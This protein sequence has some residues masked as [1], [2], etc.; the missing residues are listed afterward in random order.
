[1]VMTSKHLNE[2]A[3]ETGL[4]WNTVYKWSRDP[5]SVSVAT[6]Y[7]IKS[8]AEKLGIDTGNATA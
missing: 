6:L 1:M 5:S 7:A 2:I 8:A 4:H 3:A